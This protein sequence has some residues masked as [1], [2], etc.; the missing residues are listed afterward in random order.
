LNKTN[1][2]SN[3]KR[4]AYSKVAVAAPI[5]KSYASNTVTIGHANSGVTAGTYDSVTVNAQGHV[6]AGSS[7]TIDSTPTV[8]SQNLVTSG[9]VYTDQQ[10]QQ[11]ETNAI[12]N[13]GAKN[14]VKTT[15][16]SFTTSTQIEVAPITG[17]VVLS[18]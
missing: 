3:L 5:T 16:F 18:A 7:Y 8:N 11:T 4:N 13:L 15:T 9:G 1:G 10:R 12:A 17:T 14:F 2:W 6:T